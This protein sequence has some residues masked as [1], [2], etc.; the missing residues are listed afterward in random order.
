M[1]PMKMLSRLRYL[2]SEGFEVASLSVYDGSSDLGNA[3]IVYI[4]RDKRG[5]RRLR[6]E[7]FD[8]TPDEMKRASQLFL[9][10]LSRRE[11]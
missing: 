2:L 1:L 5:A 3:S 11:E 7:E 10:T 6:S 8:V 4:V 9:A